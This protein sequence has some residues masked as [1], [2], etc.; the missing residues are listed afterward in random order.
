VPDSVNPRFPVKW[1]GVPL[2]VLLTFVLV[3]CV[4]TSTIPLPYLSQSL[5]KDI[6]VATHDGK[7]IRYNAGSFE[8]IMT[9]SGSVLRSKGSVGDGQAGHPMGTQGRNLAFANIRAIE[10]RERTAFYYTGP[11][12]V[13][14]V[15]VLYLALHG[16]IKQ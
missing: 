4:H 7:T 9:D 2:R 10:S 5:D 13:A 16:A 12:L 11:V 1:V 14:F 6:V 3:G 8:V 15:V